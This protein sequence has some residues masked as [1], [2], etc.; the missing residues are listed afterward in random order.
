[1]SELDIKE[2]VR[3]RYGEIARYSIQAVAVLELARRR[4]V[5]DAGLGRLRYS[6]R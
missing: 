4:N 3:E 6:M 2:S 1:M 5:G